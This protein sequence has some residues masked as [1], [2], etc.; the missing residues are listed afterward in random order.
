M[1]QTGPG[2]LLVYAGSAHGAPGHTMGMSTYVVHLQEM[3]STSASLQQARLGDLPL[4]CMD[5]NAQERC[6][7]VVITR[8]DTAPACAD[9]TLRSPPCQMRRGGNL[10]DL[11][12]VAEMSI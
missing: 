2:E 4:S 9:R 8:E 7:V 1:E 10:A 11:E 5:S 12:K 6:P 3:W